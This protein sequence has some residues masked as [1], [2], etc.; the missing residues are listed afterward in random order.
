MIGYSPTTRR[1]LNSI[2]IVSDGQ[3]REAK[4]DKDHR[5]KTVDL[6]RSLIDSIDL[7]PV[8]ENGKIVTTFEL[9]I[10]SLIVWIIVRSRAL[11]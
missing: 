1:R 2:R 4:T 11:N 10:C 6:I 7:V 8:E 5:D 9:M 3:L